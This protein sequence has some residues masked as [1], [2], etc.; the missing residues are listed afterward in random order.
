MNNQLYTNF[1]FDLS[2]P[3]KNCSADHALDFG[4][5]IKNKYKQNKPIGHARTFVPLITVPKLSSM[6][7]D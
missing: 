2:L 3:H 1:Q 7:V 6:L 5:C 4:Q